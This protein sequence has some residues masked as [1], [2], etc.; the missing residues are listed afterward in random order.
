[1]INTIATTQLVT[2]LFVTGSGPTWK[3]ASADE[4]TPPASLAKTDGA[5]AR[6]EKKEASFVTRDMGA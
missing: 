3:R 2:M 5:A 6:I 1:M 4:D